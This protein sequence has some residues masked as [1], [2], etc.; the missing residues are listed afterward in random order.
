MRNKFPR[1]PLSGNP[2]NR[3]VAVGAM[4][5]PIA[6]QSMHFMLQVVRIFYIYYLVIKLSYSLLQPIR[7]CEVVKKKGG[8]Y[9]AHHFGTCGN[10]DNGGYGGG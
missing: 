9:E 5:A 2:L 10:G 8:A 6:S 3:E 4:Y 7:G 1:R